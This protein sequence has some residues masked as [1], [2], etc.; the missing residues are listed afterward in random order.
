MD[1]DN[2]HRVSW[3]ELQRLLGVFNI[4]RDDP[5]IHSLF[6]TADADDDGSIDYQGLFVRC[7]AVSFVLFGTN[8]H[9]AATHLCSFPFVQFFKNLKILLA[10][11]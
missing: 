7:C 11:C 9:L 3:D 4:N 10:K 1:A 2:D 5:T 6:L 8:S